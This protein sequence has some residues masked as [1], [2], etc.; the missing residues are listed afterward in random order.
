MVHREN[1]EIRNHRSIYYSLWLLANSRARCLSPEIVEEVP[2]TEAAKVFSYG[3]ALYSIST[4]QLPIRA[5]LTQPPRNGFDA[6]MELHS[7]SESAMKV[8]NE[9]RYCF[10]NQSLSLSE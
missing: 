10:M 8:M 9:R 2:I 1:V 5:G 6:R 3:M 4:A 7:N